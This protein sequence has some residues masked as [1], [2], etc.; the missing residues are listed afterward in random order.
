M[1]RGR[2]AVV[3]VALHDGEQGDREAREPEQEERREMKQREHRRHMEEAELAERAEGIEREMPEGTL[4]AGSSAGTV[5]T[6]TT[7][8]FTTAAPR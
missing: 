5:W 6:T 7:Q 3:T 8:K 2:L 4:T 1:S